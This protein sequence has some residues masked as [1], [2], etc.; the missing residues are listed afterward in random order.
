MLQFTQGNTAQVVVVT[1]TEKVTITTNLFYKFVYQHSVTKQ[2]IT[3]LHN[4]ASEESTY[5]TRYNQFT[6]DVA[7][8]F[9]SAPTGEWLYTVYEQSGAGGAQGGLLEQGKMF[10]KPATAF[11]FTKPNNITTYVIPR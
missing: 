9:A 11:T 2:Q 10:L 8:I 7:A 4:S 6:I 3:D 1:L 5:P